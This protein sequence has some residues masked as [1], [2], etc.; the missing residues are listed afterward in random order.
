MQVSNR[1]NQILVEKSVP[2]RELA[3]ATDLDVGHVNR[4]KNGRTV[5]NIVTA[6]KLAHALGMPVEELFELRP[7]R[8]SP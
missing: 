5:P 3:E 4:I 2:E 7:S 1:L 6:L 8:R